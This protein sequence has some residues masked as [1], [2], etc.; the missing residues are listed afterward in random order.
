M[1]CNFINFLLR[2][3]SY[4]ALG[5]AQFDGDDEAIVGIKRTFEAAMNSSEVKRPRMLQAIIESVEQQ[6]DDFMNQNA[7][8][9]ADIYMA[10]AYACIQNDKTKEVEKVL[11]KLKYSTVLLYFNLFQLMSWKTE[12]HQ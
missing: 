11:R 5:M 9:I 6:S 8:F 7:Y 2:R 10:L 3:T 1:I 4:E 12:C